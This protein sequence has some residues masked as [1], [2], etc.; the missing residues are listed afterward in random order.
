MSNQ[1]L[2][3]KIF[4]REDEE[5]KK[6]MYNSVK[7]NLGVSCLNEIHLLQYLRYGDVFEM[8]EM[9]KGVFPK[10]N[11]LTSSWFPLEEIQWH[12]LDERD[13]LLISPVEERVY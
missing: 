3:Y 6:M 5:L 2:R 13:C 4:M 8:Y 10:T 9:G 1:D 7:H 12:Y 11:V